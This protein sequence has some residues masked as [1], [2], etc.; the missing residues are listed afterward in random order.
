M[1]KK[2]T[3]GFEEAVARLEEII[4]FMNSGKTSL[5]DSLKLYEEANELMTFC[6]KRIAQVEKRVADLNKKR[7]SDLDVL[8]TGDSCD[9]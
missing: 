1:T 7:T 4:D 8:A 3:L 2:Q 5:D 6:D 9:S